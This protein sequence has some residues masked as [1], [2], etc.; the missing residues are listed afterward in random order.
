MRDLGVILD[1]KLTFARHVD[2]VVTRA[3]RML[4]TIIRGM[5]QPRS[6]RGGA[7]DFRAMRT[8]YYAH[9][10]SVIEYGSVVWAGAA[11]THMKRLERVQHC[12]LI[13]LASC[14]NHPTDNLD[15]DHL[16]AHF[17]VPSIKSRLHQH[18][19]LFLYKIFHG[20]IDC[21]ELVNLFPL[22]VPGRRTRNIHLWH[23]PFSRVNTVKNSM[24]TRIPI[25]CN[26]LLSSHPSIDFF[27]HLHWHPLK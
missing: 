25:T 22:S 17:Q 19:L 18:D 27:L 2:T 13:W 24:F 21:P 11:V 6:L 26:A 23:I 12:F 1:S 7:L 16:L 15:Y 5:Q 10:R 3:R 4:G 14:S 8:A 20:Q 9:V